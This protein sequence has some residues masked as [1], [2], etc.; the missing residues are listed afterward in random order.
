[1]ANRSQDHLAGFEMGALA[2]EGRGKVIWAVG[3]T[4]KRRVNGYQLLATVVL[5]GIGY[6]AG[7]FGSLSFPLSFGVS[8]FW[9]GIAVQ[10][11]GPIW[12]GGWGV[13]VG[14]LFPLLTNG[15]VGT[16]LYISL[17][18]FPSNALQALLPALAFRLW[19]ADPRLNS[20]MDYLV[21]IA[22]IT[23][24]NMLGALYSVLVVLRGYGLIGNESAPMFIW[25]WF[26]GNE[27][28]GL[29]LDILLL[30]MISACVIRSPLFVRKRWS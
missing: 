19:K 25:G 8:I 7:A 18:Y 30:K 6:L 5:F 29:I 11:V 15:V 16:P 1:M 27:I 22:S 12:V 14:A 4:E 20:G 10:N 28:A 9:T 13:L 2:V 17:A 3:A 26:G 23:L 21:L 24:G